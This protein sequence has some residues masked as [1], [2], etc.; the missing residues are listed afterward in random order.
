MR[1]IR[2]DSPHTRPDA[3]T[4]ALH[5]RFMRRA[6]EEARTALH[7]GEVPVGAVLVAG[8]EIV[9]HGFNQ[10]I[11]QVDPTAHAEIVCL[12]RA[13]KAVG[14]YR[15]P[16]SA[17]YVTLEPCLMCVGAILHARVGTLV[18]G[19][20]EPKAGAVRSVV[21]V[22]DLAVNHRFEVVEGVL[23]AE[24]RKQIQDF[25]RYRREES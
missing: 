9:G 21:Q 23:E 7:I 3:R 20:A 22:E 1:R 24:C 2:T 6:L 17:L 14:N 10:P 19:V 16:G 13:A 15:L 25:F 18:Y 11:H 12:R 5:E 8:G 4:L